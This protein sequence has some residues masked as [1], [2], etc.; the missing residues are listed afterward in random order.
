M[1]ILYGIFFFFCSSLLV[2]RNTTNF[3]M[4]ILSLANLLNS[5]ISSKA[6][7]WSLQDFL[8]IRSCHMQAK[9]NLFFSFQI[10]MPSNFCLIAL[11]RMSSTL[12]NRSGKSK[13]LCLVPALGRTLQRFL[14]KSKIELSFNPAIPLLVHI[15]RKRNHY[16]EKISEPLCSLQHYSQKS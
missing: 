12:L 15:Q 6:L 2:Y 11:I 14:K 13:H 5:F 7:Q 4:L 9:T 8:Y 10:W 16:L 3:C 1:M